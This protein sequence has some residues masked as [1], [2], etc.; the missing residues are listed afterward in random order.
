MF[1]LLLSQAAFDFFTSTASLNP[2]F[3][4]RTEKLPNCG[5]PFSESIRYI[6]SRLSPDFFLLNLK[7][8]SQNIKFSVFMGMNP[9]IIYLGKDI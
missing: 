6:F 2:I 8:P 5:L 3:S 1:I 4:K 9:D 7:F